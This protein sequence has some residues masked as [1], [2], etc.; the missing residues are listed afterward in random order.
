MIKPHSVNSRSNQV[1][2]VKWTVD[3][4]FKKK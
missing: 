2:H 4:I 3:K 1:S